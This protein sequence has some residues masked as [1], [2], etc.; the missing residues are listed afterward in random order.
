[1]GPR[2]VVG[3][4]LVVPPSDSFLGQPGVFCCGRRC[5]L[6]RSCR[7]QQALFKLKMCPLG[8][9]SPGS[10]GLGPCQVDRTSSRDGS[11]DGESGST[12]PLFKLLCSSAS[13]TL[14]LPFAAV[15]RVTARA[16]ACPLAAASRLHVRTRPC[17]VPR[18]STPRSWQ[19]RLSQPRQWVRRRRHPQP[20]LVQ[21]LRPAVLP[22]ARTRW[23]LKA[24]LP[25]RSRSRLRQ[26]VQRVWVRIG[27]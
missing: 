13:S 21:C 1:M 7:P 14:R 4:L 2:C 15:A 9:L 26:R 17:L 22:L 19:R 8:G 23:R 18:I 25:P 16:C 6:R 3:L 24:R 27:E 11:R 12:S 5:P 20:G 10:Q